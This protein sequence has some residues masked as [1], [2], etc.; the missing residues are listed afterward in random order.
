M[1]ELTPE[2]ILELIEEKGSEA[3]DLSGKD[4]EGIDLG[5]EKAAEL[6]RK[7]GESLPKGIWKF[8][9]GT[10]FFQFTILEGEDLRHANLQSARLMRAN[11]QR[12]DLSGVNL[13]GADLTGADLQEAWL[14]EANLQEAWLWGANLQGAHLGSANLQRA[15][16]YKAKLYRADLSGANLQEVKFGAANLQEAKLFQANLRGAKLFDE[17]LFAEPDLRES[18]FVGVT[19]E[20]TDPEFA[21]VLGATLFVGL[22]GV[23]LEGAN[24]RCTKLEGVDLTAANLEG[25]YF[26]GA[27]LDRTRLHAEQLKPKIGEEK[28]KRWDEAK[29][30]Y[31]LLKNNFRSLGR[32]NDAR[33]AYV[34]E[35]NTERKS[36]FPSQEGDGEVENRLPKGRLKKKLEPI[37]KSWLYL[38]LF[39]KPRG[40]RIQRWLW[41][42]NMVWE[43]SC[44][45]GESI[46][47]PILWAIVITFIFSPAL[48]YSFGGIVQDGSPLS[49][50]DCIVLSMSSFAGLTF[51]EI[52]SLTYFGRVWSSLEAMAAVATFALVMYTFGRRLG[53]V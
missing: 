47:L 30:A 5:S 50:A 21:N 1:S 9:D 36:Y 45:Y 42:R 19:D 46:L 11:L 26:Y 8:D 22:A 4:L 52:T 33:W 18:L 6:A 37:Y 32:Y 34:K 49:Y 25:A 17:A 40:I 24:L 2:Q 43:I 41:L 12:A 10:C 44:N 23:N 20:R 7:Y 39:F 28:D 16:L 35:R 29:E 15:F 3:L 13:E 27:Y 51:S 14:S 53:G 38:K 31:L 48:F